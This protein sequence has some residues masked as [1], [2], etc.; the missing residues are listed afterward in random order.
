MKSIIQ[1][2]IKKYHLETSTNQ[3]EIIELEDDIAVEA[4]LEI[5]LV[6][7]HNKSQHKFHF[8]TLM[9]TPGLECE[10]IYGILYNEQIINSTQDISK[11][12]NLG[13]SSSNI[14]RVELT[15][16]CEFNPE[17]H[18]RNLIVN[19]SCGICSQTEHNVNNGCSLLNQSNP[20]S[21]ATVFNIVN[22]SNSLQTLFK[23]T[24]GVHGVG[25]F[26]LSGELISLAEDV[27]RHNACDKVLGSA[28]LENLFPLNQHCLVFS[29][30]VSFELVQKAIRC[31]VSVIL[32]LGAPSS[33]AVEMAEQAG[34][35][36]IGFIRQ[37]GFNVYSHSWRLVE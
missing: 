3:N 15:E 9:R 17:S 28:L 13:T 29:G 34:I 5:H 6:Y 7:W 16:R 12:R 20:I 14:W 1:T 25:L 30:R 10:L 31:Q 23:K 26:N 8:T 2:I 19:S 4:P 18:R 24:G 37:Q 27:G 35:T 11:I 32:A 21:S 22:Q 36:L 33:L